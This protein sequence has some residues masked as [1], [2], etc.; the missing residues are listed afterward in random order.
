MEDVRDI[1]RMC[2]LT[3]RSGTMKHHQSFLL[4]YYTTW[5][6][7]TLGNKHSCPLLW[8]YSSNLLFPNLQKCQCDWHPTLTE[9]SH[10]ALLLLMSDSAK[11]GVVLQT[12]QRVFWPPLPF[13]THKE[14]P[15][16]RSLKFT[17]L[18]LNIPN[19]EIAY[20]KCYFY[21]IFWQEGEGSRV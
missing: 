5:N 8:A 2:I 14:N 1:Y 6:T 10:C 21:A 12:L 11:T 18:S 4:A 15:P 9:P 7:T 19:L 13:T 3:W 16:P 17:G 20:K